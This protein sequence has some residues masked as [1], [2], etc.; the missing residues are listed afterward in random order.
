MIA[1]LTYF[2]RCYPN[3]SGL[4]MVAGL[5]GLCVVLA[6]LGSWGCKVLGVNGKK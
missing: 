5:I 1:H 4:L 2:C 6:L 3:L